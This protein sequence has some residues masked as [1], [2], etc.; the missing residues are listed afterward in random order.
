MNKIKIPT[1]KIKGLRYG[2]L[3]FNALLQWLEMNGN[4][5]KASVK[6]IS[7]K[8]FY[9]SNKNLQQAIDEYLNPKLLTK[10]QKRF[11]KNITSDPELL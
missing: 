8:L 9:I 2:Q 10:G 4:S 3:I 5:K 7:Q 1:K 11:L 6:Y